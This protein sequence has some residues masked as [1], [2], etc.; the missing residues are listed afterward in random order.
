MKAQSGIELAAFAGFLVIVL[1]VF[2]GVSLQRQ[3]EVV[4][5]KSMVEAQR[6]GEMMAAHITTA[7]SVGEGYSA[8]FTLPTDLVGQPYYFLSF[9]QEQRV[10][11]VWGEANASYSAPVSTSNFQLNL[12][13][14][15]VHVRNEAG[16]IYVD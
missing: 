5:A 6:V 11:V 1:M 9:P 2:A 14:T 16:V 15:S 12:T 4:R 8:N 7:V 10:V 13:G 3:G